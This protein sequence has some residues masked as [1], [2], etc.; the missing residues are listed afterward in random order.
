MRNNEKK[1]LI[2]LQNGSRELVHFCY[3]PDTLYNNFFD[4]VR[5]QTVD[6]YK[7]IAIWAWEDFG[8]KLSFKTRESI[9]QLKDCITKEYKKHCNFSDDFQPE[10]R[11]A[12]RAWLC[13][14]MRKYLEDLEKEGECNAP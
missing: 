8:S 5:I 6:I 4:T 13:N 9:K 2:R 12:P 11:A 10:I 1:V 7:Y 14:H 3:I